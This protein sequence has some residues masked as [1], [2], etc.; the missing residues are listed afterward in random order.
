MV[1]KKFVTVMLAGVI[2]TASPAQVFADRTESS[3]GAEAGWELSE[4]V[5][6]VPVEA[7]NPDHIGGSIE[8]STGKGQRDRTDYCQADHRRS[9]RAGQRVIRKRAVHYDDTAVCKGGRQA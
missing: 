7:E 8:N 2:L 9:W 4:D 1:N 3:A 6:S 5:Y